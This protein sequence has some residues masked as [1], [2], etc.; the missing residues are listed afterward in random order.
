M[1]SRRHFLRAAGVTVALPWLESLARGATAVVP[2]PRRMLCIMA[3][4]GV[5]PGNFF[6]KTA[7]RDYESTP[8]LDI[9]AAHRSRMTVFSGLS[10][11]D[12]SDGHR[13]TRTFLSGG[14]TAPSRRGRPRA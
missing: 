5:L 4:M 13:S 3:D 12:N 1:A 7:G 8:Y 10:H 14:G 6:P 2:P 11:Q 9:I